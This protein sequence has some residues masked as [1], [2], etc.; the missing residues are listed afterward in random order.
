MSLPLPAVQPSSLAP[1][2]ATSNGSGE[3]ARETVR[4]TVSAGT[5]VKFGFFAA[6]GMVW[7]LLLIAAVLT[8]VT[9]ALVAAGFFT[10]PA[11]TR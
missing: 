10:F 8:V 2:N 1:M 3:Q 6:L 7:L 5:A 9:F 11:V 4:F